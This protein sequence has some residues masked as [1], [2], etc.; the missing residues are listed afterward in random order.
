M[1]KRIVGLLFLLV[2]ML[3]MVACASNEVR[4]T[5]VESV[6]EESTGDETVVSETMVSETEEVEGRDILND[7][8]IPTFELASEDLNDG[9]WDSEITNTLF[10]SN[11]SPELSWEPVEGASNYVIYMVDLSASYWIHWKSNNVTETNLP[12]GFEDDLHYVGPYP[13]SGT[14]EYVI[15]VFALAEPV[16]RIGGLINAASYDFNGYVRDLDIGLDGAVGNVLSYGEL[17]G[18]YTYGE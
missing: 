2:F 12:Q 7:D 13:P 1:C 5:S 9:V 4:E 16:E 18:T 8:T 17:S 10:G 11:V 6:G 14:H 15:Y 3:G